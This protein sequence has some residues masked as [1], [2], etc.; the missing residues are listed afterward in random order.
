MKRLPLTSSL[1]LG[2]GLAVAAAIPAA[3]A[4]GVHIVYNIGSTTVSCQSA[5]YAITGGKVVED[6]QNGC[7]VRVWLHQN[8]DGSG[9]AYCISP[10]TSRVPPAP[11][12]LPKNFFVS[13]NHAGCTPP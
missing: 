6:V 5:N 13:A 9:W 1:A 7:D 8:A 2:A 11:Y 10:F 12:N 4:V 3:A